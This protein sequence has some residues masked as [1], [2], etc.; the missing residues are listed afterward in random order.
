MKTTILLLALITTLGAAEAMPAAKAENAHGQNPHKHKV[1]AVS[2]EDAIA[3]INQ[4]SKALGV[5][6][7]NQRHS[8]EL[9]AARMVAHDLVADYYFQMYL[10][11]DLKPVDREKVAEENRGLVTGYMDNLLYM[12][13]SKAAFDKAKTEEERL[14]AKGAIAGRLS[15]FSFGH[16]Y[17][18]LKG[19]TIPSYKDLGVT[20]VGF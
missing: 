13:D 16:A 9:D 7:A 2:M 17:K 19:K 1:D 18:A 10:T 20:D 8:P 3:R 15:A 5:T 11:M 12:K 6:E 4:I 14:L